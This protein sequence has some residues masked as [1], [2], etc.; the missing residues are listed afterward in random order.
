[1]WSNADIMAQKVRKGIEDTKFTFTLMPRR[2]EPDHHADF[3]A[4][5]VRHLLQQTTAHNRGQ[6]TTF[7]SQ[8][9]T[10]VLTN[11]SVNFNQSL[12]AMTR[13]FCV[14]WAKSYSA[15]SKHQQLYQTSM[16]W[17]VTSYQVRS[18]SLKTTTAGTHVREKTQL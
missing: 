2:L 16:V 15:V 14:P 17:M 10:H 11:S 7:G 13:R 1:M 9:I 12:R 8:F 6:K 5:L 18:H 4:L 3:R